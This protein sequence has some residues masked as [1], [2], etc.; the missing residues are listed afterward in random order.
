[1]LV[2]SIVIKNVGVSEARDIVVED[3]IPK[4]TKLTGTVPRA[5]LTGKKLIWKIGNLPPN[6]QRKI[7]IRVVPLEA[8]EI[9]SVATVNFVA[10][11]A[12]ETV[13]T[14]PRLEFELSAPG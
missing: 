12:A 14:A 13:V 1:P 7:S 2:Y 5:E 9:G 11:A 4:G 10:E 8:G 3:R 6:D